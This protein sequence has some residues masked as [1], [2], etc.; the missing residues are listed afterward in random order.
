M[1]DIGFS[2]GALALGDFRSALHMLKGYECAAVELSA[3]R[4]DE[5]PGLMD[6]LVELEIHQFKYVSVHAPSKLRTMREATV[7]ELLHPCIDRGWPVIVHPDAIG[8]YGCWS[9]FGKLLCIENMDKRNKAGRRV[10]EIEPYFA[11]LPDASFCLDLGHARQVDA[12]FG[13]AR[14]LLRRF[15]DRLVQ[16]HLSEVNAQSRHSR[17]SMATV[18]AV[19]EIAHAIP[20]V[21]VI[22]ESMMGAER[23]AAELKLAS[24][25]FA[26]PDRITAVG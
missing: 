8:D 5:L 4:E 20:H 3:L 6:A 19:Q 23:I 13:V 17:L 1:R 26:I 12:T 18:W 22:I 7:A 16:V 10:D 9:D 24:A 14:E 11:A 25:C 2:T 21:P 15:G